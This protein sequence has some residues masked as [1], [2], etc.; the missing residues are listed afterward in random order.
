VAA[1]APVAPVAMARPPAPAAAPAAKAADA[2]PDAPPSDDAASMAWFDD[3]PMPAPPAP[4]SDEAIA[5]LDWNGLKTAI[6]TCTRCA[7][8]VGRKGV[9]FGRGDR[10]ADWILVGSGPSRADER[11]AQALSGPAGKLLDNMLLA[12]GVQ[13]EANV[14]VTNLVKCRP[15]GADGAER[16]P[17]A[18]ESAACR[19]YLERELALTRGRIVLTLGQAAAAGLI[20]SP[21]AARGSVRR[22]GEIPVIATYHPQDM[23][24][25]PDSKARAWG[26]LCLAKRSHAALD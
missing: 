1:P 11:D 14:Y 10:E 18:E 24:A 17:S 21:A 23:L 20:R 5:A 26:D 6:S 15:S 9:V 22:L 19:P 13:A 4:V 2:A 8:S 3:A 25:Q 12:I 7:L 16:A